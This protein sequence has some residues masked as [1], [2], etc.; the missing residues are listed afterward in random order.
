MNRQLKPW[1]MSHGSIGAMENS[2]FYGLFWRGHQSENESDAP[3]IPFAGVA[4]HGIGGRKWQDV[5]LCRNLL[6]ETEE[7]IG[8]GHR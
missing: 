7:E 5:C 2:G 6:L 1:R 3:D 8:A 4:H